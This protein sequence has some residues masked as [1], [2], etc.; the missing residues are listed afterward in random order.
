MIGTQGAVLGNGGGDA[1]HGEFSGVLSGFSS[2][3]EFAREL[4]QFDF[5]KRAM[6]QTEMFITQAI[7]LGVEQRTEFPGI[8]RGGE[9]DI[10]GLKLAHQPE[11]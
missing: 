2:V 5:Q 8:R 11:R 6:R 4:M 10:H 9:S 1:L 3:I 7:D